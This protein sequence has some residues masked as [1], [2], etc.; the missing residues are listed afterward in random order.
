[1]L[2]IVLFFVVYLHFDDWDLK[3]A[4]SGKLVDA[5]QTRSIYGNRRPLNFGCSLWASPSACSEGSSRHLAFLCFHL[6]YRRGCRLDHN[7]AVPVSRLGADIRDNR[8]QIAID[9]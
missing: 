7:L 4:T 8:R 5:C 1:M 2:F 6:L 3:C 9:I